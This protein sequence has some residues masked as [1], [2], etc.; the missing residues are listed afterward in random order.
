MRVSSFSKLTINELIT[1]KLTFFNSKLIQ[2]GNPLVNMP[3][4]IKGG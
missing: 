1:E 4:A 3:L 2:S